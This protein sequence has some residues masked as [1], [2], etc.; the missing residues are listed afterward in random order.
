MDTK[1]HLKIIF[2][3]CIAAQGKIAASGVTCRMTGDSQKGNIAYN[4]GLTKSVIQGSDTLSYTYDGTGRRVKKRFG[5]LTRHYADGVEYSG[6]TLKFIATPEGR[7]RKAGAEWQRDY[8]LKDHLGNVRVVLDAGTSTSGASFSSSGGS[9][10]YL[11]TMEENRAATED[12]YFANLNETRTD[13]PY[14]YPDKNPLN[15]KL[16]KVP[17][18]SKGLSILLRV[19]AGDTISINAKAFY[20]MDKTLPGKGVD[21]V[22]VVGSAITA[23]TSPA[24]TVLGEAARLAVDLGAE[25]SQSVTLRSALQ[26][27]DSQKE[28]KPQSGIN[29]ILYNNHMEVVEAN[30]GVLLVEDRFNEIQT[31]ATDNLIMQEAGFLEVYIN[32]EAQTPVYYDNSLQRVM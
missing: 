20:N 17:G 25:A 18:K 5:G 19:L 1:Y 16:S 4:L 13:V 31:L 28:V 11:A 23:M 12:T 26:D 24:S 9:V 6:D 22:P 2:L 15:A 8:F 29:F 21:I 14:N 3:W 30:T 27:D 7:I 10:T 32:N